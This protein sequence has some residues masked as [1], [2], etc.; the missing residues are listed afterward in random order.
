[1]KTLFRRQAIEYHLASGMGVV[2]S[3]QHRAVRWAYGALFLGILGLGLWL[4]KWKVNPAL[5]LLDWILAR[6]LPHAG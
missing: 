5:S 1:M 4:L 6:G 3:R 2:V